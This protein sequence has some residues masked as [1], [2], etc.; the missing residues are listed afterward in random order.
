MESRQVELGL[1]EILDRMREGARGPRR[2]KAAPKFDRKR[3]TRAGRQERA[4]KKRKR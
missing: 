2:S 3:K 1:V 4:M